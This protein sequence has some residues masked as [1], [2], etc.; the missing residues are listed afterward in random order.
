MKTCIVGLDVGERRIGMSI[1]TE[2]NIARPLLTIDR[3]TQDT[4]GEISKIVATHS[5]GLL[6]VGLPRGLD[7][8]DTGQTIATRSFASEMSTHF[9]GI[10]IVF[11]DEAGTSVQA[12][13]LLDGAKKPYQKHEVDSLAACLILEDYLKEKVNK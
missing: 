10:R 2:G 9:E 13:E 6:V 7:G 11:Q 8:Q 1:S 12:R 4:W 3:K 5:P